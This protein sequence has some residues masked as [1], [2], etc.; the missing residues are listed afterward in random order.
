MESE[1]KA[2]NTPD[3]FASGVF[4]HLGGGFGQDGGGKV[5]R[6]GKN[7]YPKDRTDLFDDDNTCWEEGIYED[8]HR[9]GCGLRGT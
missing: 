3:A 8:H 5:D 2:A 1:P 4:L 6:A 9:A 7:P